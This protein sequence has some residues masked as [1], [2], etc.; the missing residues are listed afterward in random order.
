[1]S[2][3]TAV[4]RLADVTVN[5]RPGQ[6]SVSGRRDTRAGSVPGSAGAGSA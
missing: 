1:M 2:I 3:A 6:A 4:A 5:T